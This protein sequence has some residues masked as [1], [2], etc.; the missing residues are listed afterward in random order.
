MNG[1]ILGKISGGVG[2]LVLLSSPFAYFLTGT[3]PWFAVGA[4]IAG[5]VMVGVYLATNWKQFGQFA[6][7]RSTFYM[8]FSAVSVVLL[9]GAF[10]GANYVAYKKNVS[11]DLTDKKI[12]SL[13][14]QTTKALGEL[15]EKVT[16]I[17]FLPPEH[18]YYDVVEGLLRRYHRESSDK[19]EYVFKDP[20]KNPDLAA[21]YHL[22]EG[23]TTIVLSRGEGDGAAHTSLNMISEEAVTNALIKL[24]AVGEQKV[25]FTAG[26]GEW[27]F[28]PLQQTLEARAATMSEL[29]TS[30]QQEGYTP[31]VLNL[32]ETRTV[33]KDAAIVVVA[34]PKTA[35][36]PDE[37]E[38]LRKYLGEGGRVLVFSEPL[39]D[40]GLDKLLGEYGVQL[41]NGIVAEQ[42]PFMRGSPYVLVESAYGQHAVT[43]PL[44]QLQLPVTFPTARGV[45]VLRD[46]LLAGV[47]AKPVVLTSPLAWQELTPN[48]MPEPNE[49]EK[50]GQ[51][52]LVVASTRS[53]T[54]DTKDKRFDEA[55]LMV[56]GDS[57]LLLDALWGHEGNRN[58][59]LNTF[60]WASNQVTRVTIRP[61]DR[62]ISALELN[63]DSLA[64]MRFFANYLVPVLLLGMGVAIWQ[65]RRNQ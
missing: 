22:R 14:P 30:L 44:I 29:R 48:D 47:S 17:A 33:P 1:S 54:A 41:D 38:M 37:E 57:Q 18:E 32:S 16:A 9:A 6:S 25:Y 19:F 52:P 56:F 23:Q 26:H 40:T 11:W 55:R 50:L 12:H 61:P 24:N 10:V 62:D 35:F 42:G 21:K 53:I 64:T 5:A 28:D 4:A 63:A 34:G 49:G 31:D 58:L 51:V 7:R 27:L 20:R 43:E 3:T 13:A 36:T 65:V 45:T 59:V 46:G 39:V 2:L 60:G 15:K 8:V